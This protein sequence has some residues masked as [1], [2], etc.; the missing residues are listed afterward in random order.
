MGR[1]RAA[2][3]DAGAE[4][5]AKGIDQTQGRSL[6]D[7][8]VAMESALQWPQGLAFGQRAV[9]LPAQRDRH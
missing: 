2:Q 8:M 9:G 3:R 6:A 7:S 5:G 1:G 4:R